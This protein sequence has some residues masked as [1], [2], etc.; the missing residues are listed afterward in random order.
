MSG[1]VTSSAPR[2]VVTCALVPSMPRSTT[3]DARTSAGRSIPNVTTRPA[4]DDAR[5]GDALVISVGDKDH[6]R[7]GLFKN[8]RLC[9]GDVVNRSEKP[10]VRL[11][12]VGPDAHVRLGHAHQ[13]ADF[14]GVVHA[15][16]DDRDLR[17]QPQLD[18]RQ[19]QPDVVVQVPAVAHHPISRRQKLRRHF[20]RRGLAGAAG[21]GHHS[22][23]RLAPDAV[24][25]RLQCDERVVHLDHDRRPATDARAA[26]SRHHDPTGTRVKRRDGEIGAVESLAA[27]GHVQLAGPDRSRIDRHA[28]RTRAARRPR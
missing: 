15:Q 2:G 17:P 8:L 3:V 18:E 4:N 19:R 14:A 16:L 5:A 7:R 28:A 27:N 1:V 24:R 22:R 25:Q 23:P 9:I 11:A 6:G 26:A 21:D 13:P 10:E 12:D 20:L